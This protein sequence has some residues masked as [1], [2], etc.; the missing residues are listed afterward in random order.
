AGVVYYF[1]G[2]LMAQREAR[3]YGSRGLGLA[4]AFCCT[5]LVWLLP[6]FWQALLAVGALGACVGVAAWGSFL[7]GRA[8][9][10]PPPAPRAALALTLLAGLFVVSVLGKLIVGQW[11]HPREVSYHYTLDRQGRMLVVRWKDGGGPIPPVTDL[12]GRVPPDLEGEQVDRN[13]IEE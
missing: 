9:A 3:W 2:M 11:S 1:A 7:A 4:A 6:E 13:L 5:V 8:Y 12:D 10:P